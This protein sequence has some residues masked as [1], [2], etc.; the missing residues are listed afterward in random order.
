MMQMRQENGVGGGGQEPRSTVEIFDPPMCCPTGM[1]GPVPDQK[2]L[3]VQEMIRI[4]GTEG[5]Q[6]TRYEPGSNPGAFMNAPE[7]MLEVRLRSTSVLPITRVN[8][9]VV[10][11]GAYP[12]IDEIHAALNGDG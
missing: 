11:S 1:C 7:V 10:K 8:G 3:D 4:L 9:R 6:V 5:V 12:S 2:M